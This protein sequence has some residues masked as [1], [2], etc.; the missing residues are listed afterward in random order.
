MANPLGLTLGSSPHSVKE[1]GAGVPR[2]PT[3]DARLPPNGV[4]PMQI[5]G[6]VTVITG[7]GSGIG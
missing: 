6:T 5:D 1:A 7:G 2:L 4:S 3:A